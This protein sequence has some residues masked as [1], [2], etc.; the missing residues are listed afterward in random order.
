MIWMWIGLFALVAVILVIDL[1]IVHRNGRHLSLR[2]SILWTLVWMAVGAGFSGVVYYLWSQGLVEDT[3]LTSQQAIIAYLTTWVLELSLSLDNIFVMALIFT[4]WRIA[5]DH[6]HT[7]LF[8]GILGAVLFRTLMIV[9][10]ASVV[11]RFEWL[12]PVFGFYLVYQGGKALYDHFFRHEDAKADKPLPTKFLGFPMVAPD[13]GGHF[14]LR[15]GQGKLVVTTLIAALVAIEGADLLFAIDSVP[16][17]LSVTRETWIV[18]SANVLAIIG[19]RSLYSV[20]AGIL[21]RYHELHIALGLLLLFI[22]T[23]MML[24]PWF[25][26]PNLVSLSVIVTLLIGGFLTGYLRERRDGQRS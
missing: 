14:F 26:L 2:E 16:A 11:N 13:H 24:L 3:E 15:D 7:V 22:G 5:K 9:F 21:E 6:Q 23:K 20:L 10:G 18:I 17:A 4:R 8:Y 25:H 19:L 1:G 12:L